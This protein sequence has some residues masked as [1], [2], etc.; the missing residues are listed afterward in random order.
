MR[1]EDGD[2]PNAR[3]APAMKSWLDDIDHATSEAQVVAAVRDYCSLVHPRDLDPL[4]SECRAIHI[5]TDDDLP[6]LS[7]RLARELAMLRGRAHET[8]KLR[9]L[10]TYLSHASQ[11][12]GELRGQPH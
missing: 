12:L 11:R 2:F 8:D 6:Q 7:A 5:E 9:D 1:D 4:P 10:V 3:S